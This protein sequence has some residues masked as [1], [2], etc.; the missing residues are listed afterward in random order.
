[1]YKK[2]KGLLNIYWHLIF[3]SNSDMILCLKDEGSGQYTGDGSVDIHGQPVLKSNTGKWKACFFVLGIPFSFLNIPLGR[4]H[5]FSRP[6]LTAL[7]GKCRHFLLRTPR[8]LWDLHESRQLPY[9][10]TP[11]RKRLCR[12]GC[13]HLAGHLLSYASYRSRLG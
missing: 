13:H 10:E 6:C 2:K 1:M 8:L 5:F 4:Q 9:R 11:P 3:F 12:E 7:I